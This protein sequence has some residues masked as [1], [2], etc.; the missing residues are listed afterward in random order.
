MLTNNNNNN[1]NNNN[2]T[3]YLRAEL[4]TSDQLK[5]RQEYQTTTTQQIQGN[6]KIKLKRENNLT[7]I[8]QRKCIL[9]GNRTPIK[10]N[11]NNKLFSCGLLNQNNVPE[12]AWRD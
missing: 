2:I 4:N 10:N 12:F 9:R 3:F 5:I 1:N 8:I 7:R 11:N 6:A